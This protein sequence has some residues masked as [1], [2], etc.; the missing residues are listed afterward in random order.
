MT[1]G[2]RAAHHAWPKAEERPVEGDSLH[3][4]ENV[5][6]M[7]RGVPLD[8][9]DRWP[10]LDRIGDQLKTWAVERRSGLI[11]C[12]ALKRA[13]RDRLLA[14]RP[15]LVFVYLKGSEAML[16]ERVK[17]RHYEYMPASLLKSQFDALE[18]PGP[19]EP[20]VT[21]DGGVTP[22]AEVDAIVQLLGGW[23]GAGTRA[24]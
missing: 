8:D 15:D 21:V 12:S 7:R 18:E 13:Y 3:P 14:A 22:E 6:K 10:W 11:T 17:A 20:V 19:D 5:E 2:N 4:A 9:A 24:S 1:S 23:R 16:G